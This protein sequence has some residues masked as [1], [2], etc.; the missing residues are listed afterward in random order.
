MALF[1]SSA[2]AK[3]ILETLRRASGG[4][5]PNLWA[6]AAFGY[7]L[8][9]VADPDMKPYDSEGQEYTE[10]MFFGQ[11]E[12]PLRALLRQRLKRI[13]DQTEVGSLIKVHVER[14]L[15]YF[16]EEFKRQN[17]RGDE[18]MLNLL[19]SCLSSVELKENG[20]I[21]SLPDVPPTDNFEILLRLGRE[22]RSEK[23]IHHVLN[24]PGGTS[25]IAIMGRTGTG[26]TRSSLDI[27]KNMHE[28]AGYKVPFLIFDYA[29][30]DIASNEE[31]IDKADARVIKL[32]DELI[33]LAPLS[34]IEAGQHAIRLF[35]RRFRDTI[36]SV[37][38][39]GPIQKS[40]CLDL[41]TRL[42]TDFA[43][44]TP[45]I[46][47]LVEFVKQEYV[48]NRWAEDSLLA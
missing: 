30:G 17:R 10:K 46:A 12:E 20:R 18:M 32:P 29:K 9:L 27:L 47:D 39:L 43:P 35:A 34:V 37:V 42:C 25:H 26:K 31:F 11:D 19:T 33:P 41:I 8:S 44:N 7:S 4:V 38:Y 21:P 16:H 15:R 5:R 24:G 23:M 28:T 22:V 45:D 1:T 2:D 14:G 6:R 13:P 3:D 36:Q 48:A 40:R